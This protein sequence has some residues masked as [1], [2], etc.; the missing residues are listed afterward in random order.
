MLAKVMRVPLSMTPREQVLDR[1]AQK[2]LVESGMD[3]HR[4][5]CAVI[6][7]LEEENALIVVLYILAHRSASRLVAGSLARGTGM[8]KRARTARKAA[9][10]S[11]ATKYS[12]L[13]KLCERETQFVGSTSS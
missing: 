4:T 6:S 10:T 12:V 7:S 3:E 5:V 9:C 2:R 1:N 11:F 13:L 8:P